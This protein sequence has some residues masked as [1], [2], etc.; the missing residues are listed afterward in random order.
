ML[1]AGSFLDLVLTAYINS[2]LFYRMFRP[3]L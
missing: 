2:L 1:V 3:Y